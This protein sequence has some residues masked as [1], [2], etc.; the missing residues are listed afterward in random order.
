MFRSCNYFTTPLVLP[1]LDYSR[2]HAMKK[3]LLSLSIAS[4]AITAAPAMAEQPGQGWRQDQREDRR[5]ERQDG[6]WCQ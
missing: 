2:E 4:M 1:A 3:F 5:E 6:R